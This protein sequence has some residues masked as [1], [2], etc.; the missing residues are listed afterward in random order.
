MRRQS[1]SS[2]ALE[3]I[4]RLTCD[5]SGVGSGGCGVTIDTQDGGGIGGTD[6]GGVNGIGGIIFPFFLYLLRFFLNFFSPPEISN[7][8]NHRQSTRDF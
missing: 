3:S 7:L 1:A 2:A 6:I 4:A 8:K 5:G